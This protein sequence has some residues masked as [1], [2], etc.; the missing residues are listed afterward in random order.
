VYLT[1]FQG[2]TVAEANDLRGL[3]LEAGGR[4]QVVK[5]RL[6]RIAVTGTPFE[7]LAE[8]LTGPNAV[9]Y[10]GEDPLEPLKVLTKFASDHGQ[11]PVKAGVVDGRMLT[12]SELERLAKVPPRK[13][14]MAEVVGAFAGPVNGLVHVLGGLVSDLVFTLQAIVDEKGGAEAA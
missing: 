10:C 1:V 3:L 5:N 9:T 7:P 11:P 4:M 6:L 2:L 13:Q 14:L 12:P 8:V